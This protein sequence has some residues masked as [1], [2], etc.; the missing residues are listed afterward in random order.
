MM[1]FPNDSVLWIL[2]ITL[3]A[4]YEYD[5]MSYVMLQCFRLFVATVTHV[6]M[7]L[8]ISC[9]KPRNQFEQLVVCDWIHERLM[10]GEALTKY[11][12]IWV[13]AM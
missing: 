11:V 4:K 6:E 10:L 5:L 2:D 12:Y 8:S 1:D 7:S 3:L 9:Q 13:D